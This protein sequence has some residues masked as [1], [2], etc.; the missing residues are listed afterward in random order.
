MNVDELRSLLD[1]FQNITTNLNDFVGSLEQAVEKQEHLQKQHACLEEEYQAL[2]QRYDTIRLDHAEATRTLQ[3]LRASH[4]AL[5]REQEATRQM[6]R[7]L[8]DRLRDKAYAIEKLSSHIS[9]TLA[10]P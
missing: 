4:E 1:V 8:H 3:E 5:V 6:V 9:A 7:E 2:Q 10:K